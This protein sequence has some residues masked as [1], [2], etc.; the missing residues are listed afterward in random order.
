M[1]SDFR[2]LEDFGSLGASIV[3]QQVGDHLAILRR[4]AFNEGLV[5]PMGFGPDFR[6]LQ[7]FGSLEEQLEYQRRIRQTSISDADKLGIA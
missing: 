1:S 2:S 5:S 6:S 7:D 3:K 4:V